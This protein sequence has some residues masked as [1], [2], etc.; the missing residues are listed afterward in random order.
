M[1]GTRQGKDAHRQ[2]GARAGRAAAFDSDVDVT[3]TDHHFFRAGTAAAV[4]E[5]KHIGKFDRW[6]ALSEGLSGPHH[7]RRQRGSRECRAY[8]SADFNP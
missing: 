6:N 2:T 7:R 1:A 3:R 8:A 4:S 5:A